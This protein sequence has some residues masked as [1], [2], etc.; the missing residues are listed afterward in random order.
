MNGVPGTHIL[1][2]R[3]TGREKAGRGGRQ[4]SPVFSSFEEGGA[5]LRGRGCVRPCLCEPASRGASRVCVP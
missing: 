3:G 2:K 1:R 4:R 5:L